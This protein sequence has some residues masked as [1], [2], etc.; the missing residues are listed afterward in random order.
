VERCGR[1]DPVMD[2]F[3]AAGA[4]KTRIVLPAGAAWPG[5]ATE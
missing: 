5:L 3:D 4:L 1:R 2:V